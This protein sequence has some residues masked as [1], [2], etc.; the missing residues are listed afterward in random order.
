MPG[1]PAPIRTRSSLH[2]ERA[3]A[4]TGSRPGRTPTAAWLVMPASSA[5]DAVGRNHD[6][7]PP[8]IELLTPTG[9]SSGA[10]LG[11]FLAGRGAGPHHFG[12]NLTNPDWKEAFLHPCN[13]HGI[14]I[15][16]RQ[17]RSAAAESLNPHGAHPSAASPARPS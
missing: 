14:V 5:L 12:V 10:F 11:R 1:G 8:K 16:V 17:H 3:A 6:R 7:N 9:G 13:T 2:A 4:R 15:Q